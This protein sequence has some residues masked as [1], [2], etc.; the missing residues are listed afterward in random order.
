MKHENI[1]KNT[2][3]FV[4]YKFEVNQPIFQDKFINDCMN[5]ISDQV[6]DSHLEEDCEYNGELLERFPEAIATPENCRIKCSLQKACKY[7]IYQFS[8]FLCILK[9]D[10]NRTCNVWGGPKQP[11]YDECKNQSMSRQ[12]LGL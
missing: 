11:S 7:W 4:T 5:R 3:I 9:R 6:C 12:A 8:E 10:G 2:D 1:N